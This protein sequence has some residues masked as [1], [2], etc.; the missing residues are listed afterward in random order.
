[1]KKDVLWIIVAIVALW[2][3]ANNTQGSTQYQT[4][5]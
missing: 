3:V 2:L 1:M 5:F 4:T